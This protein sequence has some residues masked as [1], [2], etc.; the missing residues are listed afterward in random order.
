MRLEFDI[1]NTNHKWRLMDAGQVVRRGAFGNGEALEEQHIPLLGVQVIWVAC[2]A[3]QVYVERLVALA[4]Q[5]SIALEQAVVSAEASGVRCAYKE[6]RR[7][8]VD[9]WLA[10]LAAYYRYGASCVI[11]IGSAITVDAV[12]ENGQHQ[13]GYIAPGYQLLLN[14]LLK[15]TDKVRW[16]EAEISGELSLGKDTANGVV[17]G[18]KLML[19]GFVEQAVARLPFKNAQVV[20]TGGGGRLLREG[21]NDQG[22][23]LEDLVFEGLALA[24]REV[25]V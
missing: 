25:L 10:A 5:H 20:F 19:I 7:L 9:R 23:W 24:Q 3:K 13:G 12:D 18:V 1:G 15:D 8:G 17:A 4:K 22:V 2:V 6:P 16:S 21:C 14:A 11:D